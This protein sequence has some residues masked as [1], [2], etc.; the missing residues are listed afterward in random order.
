MRSYLEARAKASGLDFATLERD[1]V[2]E[3]SGPPAFREDGLALVFD[4]PSGKI[5]LWSQSLAD[6]GADPLPEYVPH[7]EPA[8]GMLRLIFGRVP[9]HTFGRTTN[10]PILTEIIGE[11][12]A[13][14]HTSVARRLGLER[15]QRV[16]LVNQDG[17]RS[18][19]VKLLPTE[20]I[21]R[22]CCYLPHG[23]GHSDERLT[24]AH[25][26]GASD[27]DLVTSFA[28]DPLMGGTGMNVNFVTIEAGD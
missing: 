28:V 10:A 21:R 7:A 20:G 16:V 23:F 17:K 14:V 5:E 11:N 6:A 15:G 12:T 9:V 2:V 22:D 1:G 27:S 18:G 3:V 8:Q 13:W 24:R 26:R 19:A 4:T 25:G